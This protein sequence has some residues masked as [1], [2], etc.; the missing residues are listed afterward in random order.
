MGNLLLGFS[1][2]EISP[3]G[4]VYMNSSKIGTYLFEPLYASCIA[5]NDGDLTVLQ[6]TLDLRSLYG[7]A[8]PAIHAAAAE[9]TGLPEKQIVIS[10]THNHS[11]PDANL[12]HHP[13]MRKWFDEICLPAVA[14]AGKDAIADLSPIASAEGGTAFAPYVSSVRRYFRENGMFASI[15]SKKNPSPPARHETDADKELRAVRIRREGKKDLILVNFQVHAAS[16]LGQFPGRISSDIVG[17]IRDVLEADGD[18]YAMYLQGACGNTNSVTRVESEK[19]SWAKDYHDS[20]LMIGNY[21]K[22]A[23][24]NAQPLKLDSLKF[25]W[26]DFECRVNH[27][28]THLVDIAK[29][30]R[31][32]ED[33][34]KKEAMMDEAGIT[35]RYEVGSIIQRANFGETREMPLSSIVVGD[36]AIG[37]AP[38]ELFDTCGKY[39]RDASP[40]PMTFFCGY[41]M[42]YHSYMPSAIA[43]PNG[44]YEATQCHYVPGTGE[45]IA[46]ELARQV[47]ML[48]K[49]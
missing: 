42:G 49:S 30:I 16:C 41:A 9:A 26:N 43:F 1:R 32:E 37:F 39:F 21:A 45:M 38:V 3:K 29:A 10:V 4:E 13:H 15:T 31:E 34:D 44:G 17:P 36:L 22:E 20:G 47:H 28:K 35:S 7:V 33:P 5:W 12:L 8:Y 40:T 6:Y 18:A 27:A 23:L 24:K 48:K 19:A 2:S 46:L 14:Q 25:V 11:A